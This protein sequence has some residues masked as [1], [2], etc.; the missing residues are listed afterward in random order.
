MNH[1]IRWNQLHFSIGELPFPVLGLDQSEEAPS[2]NQ[3]EGSVAKFDF[4]AKSKNLV[5]EIQ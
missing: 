3:S 1:E 5:A 2:T 4:W